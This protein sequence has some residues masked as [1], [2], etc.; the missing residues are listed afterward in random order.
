MTGRALPKVAGD[1]TIEP[2]SRYT[3]LALELLLS[4]F[5]A[6]T[7]AHAQSRR[8]PYDAGAIH[9]QIQRSIQLQRQ[10]L[11]SLTELGQA[12]RLVRNAWIELRAALNGMSNRRTSLPTR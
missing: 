4:A 9:R 3:C 7:P 10:A 6:G 8:P 11:Q 2:V 5:A 12:A 1:L